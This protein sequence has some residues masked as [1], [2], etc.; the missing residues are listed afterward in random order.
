[1]GS[2]AGEPL[3]FIN[4][5]PSVDRSEGIH[6]YRFGKFEIALGSSNILNNDFPVFRYADVLMMKAESLLR[7]GKSEEAAT[8]VTEI[9]ERAFKSNPEKAEV[10]GAE[11]QEGTIYDYGLRNENNSTNEGG[12]DIPYG[13]FLDELGWEFNQEGRRRQDM[14]RF[15]VFTSKSWFSHNPNGSYRSLYP[16]PQSALNSNSNLTQNPGY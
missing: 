15:G 9:R 6:G 14:I 7:T 2:Y 16:I 11:L 5:I 8:I 12:E 4:E 13:R 10:T 3:A 1:L